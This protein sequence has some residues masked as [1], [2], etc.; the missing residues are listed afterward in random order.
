MKKDLE[1]YAK[2]PYTIILE[3]GEGPGDYWVARIAELPHCMIH[4]STPE[5]ALKEIEEVKIEW[6]ESNL[7]DGL[8]IPEPTEHKYS[9]MIRVR[10]P[11]S[12]HRVLADRASVEDVSLNQYMVT[13]LARAVGQGPA[14]CK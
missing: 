11:P 8:P 14:S 4:G 1:Y 10:M 9:G 13:A 2:L 7:E 12:L 5:D 3:K 6:L